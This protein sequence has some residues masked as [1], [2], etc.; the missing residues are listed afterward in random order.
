MFGLGNILNQGGQ[1]CHGHHHHHHHGNHDAAAQGSE[2][3]RS[4]HRHDDPSQM[5][6]QILQ[7]LT[8]GLTQGQG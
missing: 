8:Q 4:E 5:F 1:E 6:Q 2:C 3:G 7:Q